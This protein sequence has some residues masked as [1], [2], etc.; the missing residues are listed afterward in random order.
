VAYPLIPWIAVMAAGYCFG[1]VFLLEPSRRQ[2]MML[3]IGPIM[4]AGFVILRAVNLYGDPAPW[5]HQKSGAFTVLSFLNCTKYPAS[6]DFLLMTLSP[7]LLVLAWF[8]RCTWK[9]RNPLIVFGRVPFF[10]FVVHFY[11]IHALAAL[12]ALLR[13]GTRAFGFIFNPVPTMGG[14]RELYPANFGYHLWVVYVVWIGIVAALYPCCRWYMG[15]K[16]RRR[17]W[18]LSYL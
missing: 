11:A 16:A 9:D 5:S 1:Q 18:W 6:L 3:R 17:D 12:M 4:M 8:D 7:A 15:V 2:R 13:Y 14:A 10:Y